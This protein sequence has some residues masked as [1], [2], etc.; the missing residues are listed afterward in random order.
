MHFRAEKKKIK[1]NLKLQAVE[2]TFQIKVENFFYSTSTPTLYAAEKLFDVRLMM[3][4]R[5]NR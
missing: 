1:N 4:W 2:E 5:E 3:S